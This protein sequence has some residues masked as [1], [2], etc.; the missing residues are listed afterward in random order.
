MTDN[1]YTNSHHNLVGDRFNDSIWH[2]K[3]VSHANGKRSKKGTET[4]NFTGTGFLFEKTV[5]SYKRIFLVSN[6]H[7]LV[8]DN[9]Y[10]LF[11]LAPIGDPE[12]DKDG[13]VVRYATPLQIYPTP[14]E[15]PAKDSLPSVVHAASNPSID[16]AVI[17]IT[18]RYVRIKRELE[19]YGVKTNPLSD[20]MIPLKTDWNIER[21]TWC[22]SL[23]FPDNSFIH[24]LGGG[25]IA[26]N[27][28][29]HPDFPIIE[30]SQADIAQGASGSPIF[31]EIRNSAKLLGIVYAT[32]SVRM[33]ND[34]LAYTRA[35]VVKVTQLIKLTDDILREQGL[36]Q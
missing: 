10:S 34:H 9:P 1:Y 30:L 5:G 27:P 26:Q 15:Y 16:L 17:D 3:V 13:S 23:G 19:K 31:V 11:I 7:L 33:V 12:L 18:D 21:G 29:E 14:Q 20:T 25:H 22:P 24:L 36:L 32:G 4:K 28:N 35:N 6:R 8:E 2:L